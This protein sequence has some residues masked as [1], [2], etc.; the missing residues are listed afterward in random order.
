MKPALWTAI[1]IGVIFT[2][3]ALAGRASD[4]INALPEATKADT[5]RRLISADGTECGRVTQVLYKGEIQKDDSAAYAVRCEPGEDW[6]VTVKNSGGMKTNI[7]SCA[8]LKVM[9]GPECW[10]RF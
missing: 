4:T 10:G 5:F 8:M 6:V 2:P 3:A 9:G 7:L 1:A